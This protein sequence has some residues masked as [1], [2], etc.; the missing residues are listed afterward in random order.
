MH[1]PLPRP[2]AHWRFDGTLRTYQAEALRSIPTTPADSAMHIVAPP[3]S[4]KTLLGLLLA[5][6]VGHRA[7]V[8]APS[9]TIRDQWVRTARD[10]A[11]DVAAVSADGDALSDLTA[12]TYQR[13]SVTGDSSPFD[14]L[15]VRQW[16]DELTATG[17]TAA[18]AATWLATLSVD[19]PEQHAR[20]IRRRASALRR[21]FSRASPEEIAGALH[22]RALA[23]IDRLVDAGVDTVVLDE[24]HHLLD[25][26][27]LV[28]A[29]LRARIR[30]NGGTGLLIGL[31]A[32]LPSPDDVA[33][34][35]NY[36]QLLGEV[37]YEVP[38][39]AVVKE[40]HLAPYCESAC[41]RGRTWA[42]L[43]RSDD[44]GRMPRTSP[45]GG[46]GPSAPAT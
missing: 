44:G 22:P 18:D 39:P 20:G 13:L 5:A 17:R 4:G 14:E 36:T 23:L 2:L 35:Y 33:G 16:R 28:V 34:F 27:A 29:Y 31:T 25:H 40:G 8:L 32:T 12:L 21:R 41:A 42:F 1:S 38:T 19:N 3:G 10:L 6:R 9:V 45:H 46:G 43:S 26:W 11:H 30:A 24:C 15:A 37:D 7:L